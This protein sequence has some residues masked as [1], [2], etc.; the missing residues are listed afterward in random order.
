[1]QQ[2]KHILV[3]LPL[4]LRLFE[5]I[6]EEATSDEDLHFMAERMSELSW[7][8]GVKLTMNEYDSIIPKHYTKTYSPSI[9][10]TP[11]E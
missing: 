3:S 4:I 9:E 11:T 10:T 7:G 8:D 1:M 6:R 5:Y 2:T